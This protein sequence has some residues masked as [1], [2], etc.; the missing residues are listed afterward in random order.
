MVFFLVRTFTRR[1][2]RAS[3]ARIE[4]PCGV[5]GPGGQHQAPDPLAEADE[6]D[7]SDQGHGAD[8]GPG[9][10][11]HR[12]AE[13]VTWRRRATG[14]RRAVPRLCSRR[15]ASP[16]VEPSVTFRSTILLIMV[17]FHPGRARAHSDRWCAP[18]A[19]TLPLTVGGQPAMPIGPPVQTAPRELC[20]ATDPSQ[21]A[22]T[23][24]ARR[25]VFQHRDDPPVTGQEGEIHIES[26]RDAQASGQP[27]VES[28]RCHG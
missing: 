10:E 13:Q 6:P 4:L 16:P 24:D 8:I 25:A 14:G 3:A 22:R 5:V 17:N 26:A 7:D 19:P 9:D 12:H 23:R 2:R 27:R 28:P 18:Q 20:S 1:F 21:D 11:H 15:R